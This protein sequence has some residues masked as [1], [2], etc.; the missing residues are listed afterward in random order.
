MQEL[1]KLDIS[2]IVASNKEAIIGMADKYIENFAFNGGDAAKDWAACEKLIL[3]LS[4]LQKGL[5]PYVLSELHNCDKEE[6]HSIGVAVK[7]VNTP[8]KYD[9]SQSESWA[10]QKAK[11]DA[12]SAQL[13]SI[14]AFIK[15]IDKTTTTVDTET[16]E[17]ITFYPPAKSSGETVRCSIL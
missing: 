9:F 10:K 2:P 17:T 15:S 12:E 8:T 14:E 4:E 6:T 11:V 16:G 7:A 13:K 5:K 3:L 1:A